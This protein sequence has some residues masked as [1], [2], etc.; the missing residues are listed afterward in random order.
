MTRTRPKPIT[1]NPPARPRRSGHHCHHSDRS[2]VP[3]PDAESAGQS[4][5]RYSSRREMRVPSRS[6]LP[7]SSTAAPRSAR[8]CAPLCPSSVL[9]PRRPCRAKKWRAQKFQ[10]TVVLDQYPKQASRGCANR[11]P[12]IIVPIVIIDPGTPTADRPA[13]VHLLSRGCMAF[14]PFPER[15]C[16][17]GYTV[18]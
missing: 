4:V 13:V 14:L 9:R 8:P 15:G 16:Y 2:H 5:V 10:V 18:V 12:R 11:L 3:M 1:S 7:Q 17:F 6:K